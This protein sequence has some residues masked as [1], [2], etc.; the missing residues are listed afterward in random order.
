M[1]VLIMAMTD[2]KS[3]API[4]DSLANDFLREDNVVIAKVDAEAENARAIAAAQGITGYPTIKFFPKGADPK[5]AVPYQGPRSEEALV[6]F[7]NKQAGTHRAIGG[8]LNANAGKIAALDEIVAEHVRAH[9][10]KKLAAEVKKAASSLKDKYA[11]YYVRVAEKLAKDKDY[12]DKEIERLKK[13]LSKGSS[14]PEKVDD[15]VS[16]KNILWLFTGEDKE[17]AAHKDEL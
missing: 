17:T 1:M 12:A 13:I 8:G 3:L 2:C 15:L 4:W 6:Y 10:F 5:D 7:V 11:Q 16:R 9:N 14:A